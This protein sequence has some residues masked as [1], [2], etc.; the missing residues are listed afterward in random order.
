[1]TILSSFFSSASAACFV[2]LLLASGAVADTAGRNTNTNT[3]TNT[4][5]APGSDTPPLQL[6]AV[7]ATLRLDPAAVTVSGLSSGGY[8]AVQMHVA[9][10]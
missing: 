4:S 5:S 2:L 8:M 7:A 6:A 3:S 10:R 1:M 9:F